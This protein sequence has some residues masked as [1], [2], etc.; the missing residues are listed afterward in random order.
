MKTS[1]RGRK[2][3]LNFYQHIPSLLHAPLVQTA[4]HTVSTAVHTGVYCSTY[5]CL[6][7]DIQVST[8]V[9]TGVYYSTY[10]C[11]LQY[12]QVSTE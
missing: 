10:R 6:L 12:I 9:H 11:L 1:V 3:V 2:E 4:V 7:K 5:R 8:T